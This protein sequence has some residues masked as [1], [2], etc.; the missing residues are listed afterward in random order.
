LAGAKQ[1]LSALADDDFDRVSRLTLREFVEAVEP[2]FDADSSLDTPSF[3]FL[4]FLT[5]VAVVFT[6]ATFIL[7]VLCLFHFEG[8]HKQNGTSMLLT[9]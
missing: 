5:A 1:I 4:T 7:G 9:I 3:R 6:S 8:G 2:L